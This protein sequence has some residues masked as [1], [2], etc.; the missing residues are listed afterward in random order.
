MPRLCEALRSEEVEA[1]IY[2]LAEW[3]SSIREHTLFFQPTAARI[4]VLSR[5]KLS[6]DMDAALR[7]EVVCTD[8]IH[9]HGLWIA[10]N[11]YAGKAA[12]SAGRPLIVSP[13]GMLS[14]EALQ[15]SALKKRVIW[16]AWQ[17][18]AYRHAAAWHATSLQECDDIRTFG[19]EAPVA[20]IPNG[21][22]LPG[23]VASHC[24]ARQQRTIL[25]LS[26]I[27]PKKGL[28][29]LLEAWRQLAADRPDWH[30]VIAGPDEGGHRAVLEAIVKDMEI[31][32]LAFAGPVYGE[33]KANL[34][35]GADLFVLPTLSENFGIAVAEAL[36]AG[37]PAIVTTGAPWQGL[38]SNRCGWWIEQGIDRLFAALS[39]AT[40]LPAS[41]RKAM[42]L[43]GRDWMQRDF[44]WDAIGREMKDVYQWAT[45]QGDRPSCIHL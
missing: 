35:A 43:R 31:P 34:L 15:F 21:I 19:I 40:A 23:K 38:D 6:R 4:P 1:D 41:E 3:G 2:T 20:V 10:P 45:R 30:I 7:Q 44:G 18:P 9:S 17:E 22:D 8:I 37:L 29:A 24:P 16:K 11:I 39:E 42:G 26:R 33:A 25:F 28:P 12:A 32:R 36:A 27:H 5:L 14:P 13:R